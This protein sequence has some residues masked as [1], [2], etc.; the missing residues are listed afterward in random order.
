MGEYDFFMSKLC[1]VLPANE[2]WKESITNY[3]RVLIIVTLIWKRYTDQGY[4]YLL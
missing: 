4:F 3:K 1:I 2:T